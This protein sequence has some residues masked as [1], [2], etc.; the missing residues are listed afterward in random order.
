MHDLSSLHPS[1]KR[2]WLANVLME[3][4]DAFAMGSVMEIQEALKKVEAFGPLASGFVQVGLQA[5]NLDEMLRKLAS[6]YET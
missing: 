6:Y 2:S 3:A 4:R 1:Q 5:G